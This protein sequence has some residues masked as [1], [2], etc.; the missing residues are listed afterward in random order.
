MDSVEHQA[1][2]KQNLTL[3]FDKDL[4]EQ[5][6]ISVTMEPVSMVTEGGQGL[7]HVLIVDDN[8]DMRQYIS[9]LLQNFYHVTMATNGLDAL[10]KISKSIPDLVLSDIMM[11]Q[12]DG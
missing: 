7:P 3:K 5:R 2:V 1:E 4:C 9:T 12:M 6:Q 11:P 8:S 10:S